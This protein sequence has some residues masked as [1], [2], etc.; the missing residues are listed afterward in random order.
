M[1]GSATERDRGPNGAVRGRQSKSRNSPLARPLIAPPFADL[2][3]LPRARVAAMRQAARELFAVLERCARDGRHPVSELLAASPE[4][5]TRWCYYP[6]DPVADASSGSAWFYH[7][8]DP[9]EARQWDEHGHFHCF[10]SAKKLARGAKPIALPP[11][12]D[13]EKERTVHL[14][15]LSIHGSGVPKRLFTTNRWVTGEWMYE[16]RAVAPLVDRFAIRS[17]KRFHLTSR[18]LSALLRLFHPQIAWLLQERDRAIGERRASG[19]TDFTED[20][21]VEAVS[22]IEI[23]VDAQLAALD[24]AW[25]ARPGARGGARA[26]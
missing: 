5:F 1:S 2:S 6:P 3:P 12:P 25:E 16:A 20:Q 11:D 15:A 19:A 7:A 18:W 23:D 26:K 10:T 22:V 14:A 9:S 13:P 24:R 8:H 17:D 4:G 21:T